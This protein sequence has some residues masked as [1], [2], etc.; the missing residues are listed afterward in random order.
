MPVDEDTLSALVDAARLSTPQ[1]ESIAQS[2]LGASVAS[3]S[4]AS[5]PAQQAR[6]MAV[7][8]KQYGLL[9]ELAS[10]VIQYGSDRAGLQNLLLGDQTGMEDGRNHNVALDLVKLEGKVDSMFIKLDAKLDAT[11]VEMRHMRAEV[12]HQ[13]IALTGKMIAFVLFALAA[14]VIGQISLLAWIGALPHG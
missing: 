9:R 13:P 2:V 12:G 1:L 14:L 5:T 6:D 3:I 11:I 7:Y 10:A 4:G 8:A